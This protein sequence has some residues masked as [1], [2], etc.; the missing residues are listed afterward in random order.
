LG[1]DISISRFRSII[2]SHERYD[3]SRILFES[4][5]LDRIERVCSSL[6]VTVATCMAAGLSEHA[7]KVGLGLNVSSVISR[8]LFKLVSPVIPTDQ[9]LL[10]FFSRAA[11]AS[12]G[13]LA[14]FR[15]EKS[16]LVWANCLLGAEMIMSSLEILIGARKRESVDS[17]NVVHSTSSS[18]ISH[19]RTTCVWVLAGSG[20]VL[21]YAPGN[22]MPI[23]MKGVLIGPRM[24]EYGL[25][26]LSVSMKGN[27]NKQFFT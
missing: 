2:G 15:L 19:I 9:P 17:E 23:W 24:F 13:I 16:L 12:L 18:L 10:R 27:D 20:L 21:Q 3:V 26:A 6:Y 25:Q 22:D 5:N 8:T 14:A 1:E 4:I 11:C 7:A